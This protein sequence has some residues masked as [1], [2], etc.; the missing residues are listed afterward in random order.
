MTIGTG[1]NHG[2]WGG[3][4]SPVSAA[5]GAQVGGPANVPYAIFMDEVTLYDRALAPSEIRASRTPAPAAS[6]SR[7]RA[8]RARMRRAGTM[9]ENNGICNASGVCQ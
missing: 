6:A 3:F 9:C 1:T 8:R 5:M 7:R 4:A 2:V